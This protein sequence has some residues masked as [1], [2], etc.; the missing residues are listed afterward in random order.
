MFLRTARVF[1]DTERY[2]PVENLDE[3]D[4][5]FAVYKRVVMMNS[6]CYD[7]CFSVLCYLSTC[8]L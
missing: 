3:D 4:V 6:R 2:G 8:L 7:P 1:T 5:A